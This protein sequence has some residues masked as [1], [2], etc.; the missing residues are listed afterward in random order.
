MKSM[1]INCF[2][3]GNNC[4]VVKYS[5]DNIGIWILCKLNSINA[6]LRFINCGRRTS[7]NRCDDVTPLQACAGCLELIAIPCA[8]LQGNAASG[9]LSLECG[10]ET[11]LPLPA[12]RTALL[13]QHKYY[14]LAN[15]NIDIML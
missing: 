5:T 13:H 9:Y 11:D 4:L 6:I 8:Q 3:S 2:V 1:Q 10:L 12:T 7:G 15:V 14:Q